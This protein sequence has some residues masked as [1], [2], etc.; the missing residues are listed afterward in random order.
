MLGWRWSS[1]WEKNYTVKLIIENEK[2]LRILMGRVLDNK[3]SET[4]KNGGISSGV[5]KFR[6][7]SAVQLR[8][9]QDAMMSR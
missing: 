4:K 6:S 2:D 1:I 3:A 5:I 8:P 7:G 9:P